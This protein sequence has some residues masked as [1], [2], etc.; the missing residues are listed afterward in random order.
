MVASFP[1]RVRNRMEAEGVFPGE[2]HGA[3]ATQLLLLVV[4]RLVL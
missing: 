1:G 3:V 2:S 4:R